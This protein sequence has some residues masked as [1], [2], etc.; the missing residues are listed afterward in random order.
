MILKIKTN[1]QDIPSIE[2]IGKV[3]SYVSGSLEIIVAVAWIIF[4]IIDQLGAYPIIGSNIAFVIGSAICIIFACL[5]IHGVR[6]KNNNLLR[7]SLGFCYTLL[8]LYMI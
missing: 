3:H 7:T 5:K 1:K 4:S 2:K 8:V 6:V